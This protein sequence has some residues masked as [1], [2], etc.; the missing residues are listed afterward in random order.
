M[1]DVVDAAVAALS[2]KISGSLPGSVKFIIEDEGA[3]MI[4]DAGVRAGDDEAEVTLTADTETFQ[5]MLT[6]E[7]NPT[8]AFMSGKL[9]VD[10]NMGLAMQL[11]SVLG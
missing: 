8:T 1:S 6:G 11:A 10:G 3:V 7:V 2:E 9:K 4:D 5:G